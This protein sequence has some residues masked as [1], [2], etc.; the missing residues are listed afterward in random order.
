MK[1]SPEYIPVIDQTISQLEHDVKEAPKLSRASKLEVYK[2]WKGHPFLRP[3][4]HE[5]FSEVVEPYKSAIEMLAV[6]V[7]G[8]GHLY[9]Q[10]LITLFQPWLNLSVTAQDQQKRDLVKVENLEVSLNDFELYSLPPWTIDRQPIDWFGE[11]GQLMV[12]AAVKVGDFERALEILKPMEIAMQERLIAIKKDNLNWQMSDGFLDARYP[13][14]Y[15]SRQQYKGNLAAQTMLA[16][17]R[18][19][20]QNTFETWEVAFKLLK[21][22]NRVLPNPDILRLAQFERAKSTFVHPDAYSMGQ[23]WTIFRKTPR[24]WLS[25]YLKTYGQ[26]KLNPTVSV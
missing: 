14:V 23:K 13:Q 9:Y 11:M 20:I 8:L 1:L 24:I 16:I 12:E 21:E 2:A 10:D 18:A 22:S 26:T 4:L 15:R 5:D 19:Q 6:G 17:R 7:V 3:I 25:L